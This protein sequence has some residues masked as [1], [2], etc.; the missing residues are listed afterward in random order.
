MKEIL[1]PHLRSKYRSTSNYNWSKL[2]LPIY[3]SPK[4]NSYKDWTSNY[5]SYL[6]HHMKNEKFS[7]L[8]KPFLSGLKYDL[9][10]SLFL[11]PH[12]IHLTLMSGELIFKLVVQKTSLREQSFV[13]RCVFMLKMSR[14]L[15]VNPR[16]YIVSD[17]LSIYTLDST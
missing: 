8:M 15:R 17:F 11:M 7:K 12:V 5:T 4:G 9:R 6:I 1:A 3:G 2:Q 10:L 13:F 16:H 14:F